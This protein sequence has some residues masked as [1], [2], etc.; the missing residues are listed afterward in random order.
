MRPLCWAVLVILALAAAPAR[1][2]EYGYEYGYDGLYGDDMEY[3]YLD[4]YGY[5]GDD[6][7]LYYEEY[8]Y[9]ADD[10][11]FG[12]DDYYEFYDYLDYD[13]IDAVVDC[14]VD[15]DGKVKLANGTA[16]CDIKIEGIDKQADLLTGGLDGVYKLYTC[17]DGKPAYSRQNSPKGEER[18]LWYSREF[19]DWDV[20][21]GPK[22]NEADILLYGGDIEHHPVPL[23]VKN[24]HLG[25][26]LKSGTDK[27]AD[28]SYVPVAATIKCADGRVYKPPAVNE[29]V[30]KQ[31]PLLT[32]E[33]IEDK[34]KL[35]FEKYGRRPEPNPTVNFSFVVMLVMVG[36]TIVLAIPYLLVRKRN[37]MKGYQPVATSFAQVIQQSK[38][39]QSGHIN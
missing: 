9:Y 15:K 32:P 2:Y 4:D 38:K 28:E 16:P 3:D 33:E 24:W 27:A 37:Q 36:L 35:I 26:D 5:Y 11:V 18:V 13:E 25:G 29:A 30:Q 31:G 12:Y 10:D 7:D 34:Y 23:F 1:S 19:G 39:K 22:P 14:T 6:A 17:H 8:G 20:S 21:K